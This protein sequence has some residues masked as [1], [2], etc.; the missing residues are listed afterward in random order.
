MKRLFLL[1]FVLLI[2]QAY[3]YPQAANTAAR[4]GL[5]KNKSKRVQAEQVYICLSK[6]AYAYHAYRCRG[7]NRCKAG[8]STVSVSKAHSMGYVPCKICY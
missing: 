8:T 3:T 2:G 5:Q 1:I 6:R 7:L 4:S